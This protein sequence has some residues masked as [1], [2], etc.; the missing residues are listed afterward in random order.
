LVTQGLLLE[1]IV[2]HLVGILL[3]TQKE[4]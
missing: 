1:N 2:T 4:T 3:S